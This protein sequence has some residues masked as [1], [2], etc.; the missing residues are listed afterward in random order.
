M[1]THSTTH[2]GN[3]RVVFQIKHCT[4]Y[5][6]HD[7][8]IYAVHTTKYLELPWSSALTSVIVYLSVVRESYVELDP[9]ITSWVVLPPKYLACFAC[10]GLL[11]G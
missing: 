6:T 4:I 10:R 3:M 1:T 2:R 8:Y 11:S 5:D 9:P 7:F